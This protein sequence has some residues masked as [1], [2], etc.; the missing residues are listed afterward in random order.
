MIAEWVQRYV[1]WFGSTTNIAWFAGFWLF[2]SFI[3]GLETWV[4]AFQQQPERAYRWPTNFGFGL[5]NWGLAAMAPISAIS[6][7][8]WASRT[9]V[10]VFNQVAMPLWVSMCGSL[11]VYSLTGYLVHLVEHKSPWLWRIHRVHHLDTHLD[12]STS[13]RH[14]PLELV[15]NVLILVAVTIVF[16]LT[17]S[18]LIIHEMVNALID[19]FSHANVR[20]PE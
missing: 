17:A 20:L 5:I 7:A 4:P 12:V 19:F 3:F 6:A 1:T 16:G 13:Q 2:I 10:G 14:H 8:E 9:G 11:A 18:I 15:A